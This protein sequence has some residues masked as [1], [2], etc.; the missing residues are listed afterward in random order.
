MAKLPLYDIYQAAFLSL[1]SISP[2]FIKSGTRVVFQF[3]AT[4]E[5]KKLLE[6][7]SQNPSVLLLDFVSHLRKLRSQMIS[8]RD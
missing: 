4:K 7:Y 2:Q 8:L 3:E 5:V 6:Q 1:N